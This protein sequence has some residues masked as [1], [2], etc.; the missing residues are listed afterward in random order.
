M[1]LFRLCF[2]RILTSVSLL[3]HHLG[4]ENG[5]CE[6]LLARLFTLGDGAIFVDRM[7]SH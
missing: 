2:D 5:N 3:T 4:N 7:Q 1:L 6:G